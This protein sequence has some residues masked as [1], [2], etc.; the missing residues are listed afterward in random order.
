MILGFSNCLLRGILGFRG[1]F[2][3]FAFLPLSILTLDG[4]LAR[5]L[6]NF[7]YWDGIRDSRRLLG[8]FRGIGRDLPDLWRIEDIFEQ[9]SSRI[10]RDT[11]SIESLIPCNV[12][13]VPAYF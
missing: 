8:S 7:G 6:S 1:G 12:A 13:V 2:L 3:P 10:Y 5:A 11:R 9:P 4:D